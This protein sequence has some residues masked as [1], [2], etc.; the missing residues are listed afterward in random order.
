MRIITLNCWGGRINLPLIEWLEHADADVY[1]LQEVFD[2]PYEEF[3][4]DEKGPHRA[5]PS[6]VKKPPVRGNLFEQIANT[7]PNHRGYMLPACKWELTDV[8]NAKNVPCYFGIATFVRKDI[9]VHEI[10]TK[11]V[12]QT[13]RAVPQVEAPTPRVAFAMRLFNPATNRQVVVAHMH[14][15]WIPEG[16][17]HTVSRMLQAETFSRLIDS[18]SYPGDQV[19]VCGDFNVLPGDPTFELLQKI[20]R[21]KDLIAESYDGTRTRLYFDIPSKKG[22]SLYADY[23]LVSKE[24]K[25]KK[26]DVLY[27]PVVSDHC[28]IALDFE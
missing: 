5:D 3:Y 21:I 25:V 13:F 15:L 26:V 23:L 2:S 6:E 7:L 28:P 9:P 1:C 17:H 16:K 22:Q 20:C 14:G 24:V 8:A 12:H 18:I 11:F 27:T 19:V 10:K 4:S